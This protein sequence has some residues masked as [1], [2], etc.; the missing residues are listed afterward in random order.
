MRTPDS[1]CLTLVNAQ[2]LN[3]IS[4]IRQWPLFP[5]VFNWNNVGATVHTDTVRQPILHTSLIVEF[6]NVSFMPKKIAVSLCSRLHGYSDRRGLCNSQI[7][8]LV[9]AFDVTGIQSSSPQFVAE[10]HACWKAFKQ[11]SKIWNARGDD[12]Y[13]L[14][15]L[16]Q[17]DPFPYIVRYIWWSEC[18]CEG[19]LD[20][21][22]GN[23]A[24]ILLGICIV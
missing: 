8:R 9:L 21:A 11:W 17:Q 5:F 16:C 10:K 20:G 4:Q 7:S 3:G 13:A 22:S 1:Q 12:T 18:S 2:R 24:V 23:I 6:P 15:E 19:K 14:G